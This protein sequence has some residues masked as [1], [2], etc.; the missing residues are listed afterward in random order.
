MRMRLYPPQFETFYFN[1]PRKIEKKNAYLTW[2]RLT[3]QQQNEVIVAAKNY[4]KAMKR[5]QREEEYIKHP[6]VF[7][8][9]RKEIWKDYLLPT[10]SA[11]DAW[12]EKKLKEGK[13]KEVM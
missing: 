11:S 10:K 2:K 12:L 4:A 3:I 7:V 8:N 13:A 5:E 6:K 9:P 1:Y